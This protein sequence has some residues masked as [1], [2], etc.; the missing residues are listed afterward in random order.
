MNKL[1]IMVDVQNDFMKPDGKL[2]I[3]DAEKI[4]PNISILVKYI[5]D[6]GIPM[7]ATKDKHY[8]TDYFSKVE[9]ELDI[10]GGP[11]PM[12]CQADT[13]GQKLIEEVNIED[14]DVKL[15][16]D[17]GLTESMIDLNLGK[18]Y[19]Y[20]KQEYDIFTN[21]SVKYLFEW[22]DEFLVFGVATDYCVYAAVDGLLKMGKK[23]T[24]VTDCIKA[25]NEEDGQ[26]K[27]KELSESGVVLKTLK[28]VMDGSQEKEQI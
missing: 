5:K 20:D 23:V 12:H 22:Y 17:I 2:Y 21:I 3:K 11:F 24:I 4:I 13:K 8:G 10:N 28:E 19:S 27:L 6:K 16:G 25:V 26:K 18:V 7:I 15:Y 1:A 9:T 14:L